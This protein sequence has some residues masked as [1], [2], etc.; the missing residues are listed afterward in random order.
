MIL[1]GPSG[2]GKVSLIRTYAHSE[3]KVIK[4]YVDVKPSFVEDLGLNYDPGSNMPDD[5]VGLISFIK[6]ISIGANAKAG[7]ELKRTGFSSL[8][9]VQIPNK[10]ISNEPKNKG[11]LFVIRG[12]PEC[13]KLSSVH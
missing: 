1:T 3:N 11:S 8:K 10:V 13:L 9:P 7:V 4:Y 2:C 6:E 12:L 5:L